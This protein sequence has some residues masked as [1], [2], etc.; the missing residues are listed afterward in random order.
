MPL[1]FKQGIIFPLTNGDPEGSHLSAESNARPQPAD[2]R[3]LL[4]HPEGVAKSLL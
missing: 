1:F 4:L 3:D 2:V